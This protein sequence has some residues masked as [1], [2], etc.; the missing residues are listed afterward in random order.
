LSI[1]LRFAESTNWVTDGATIK[2][3]MLLHGNT[4]QNLL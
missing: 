3:P 1:A 2:Q 4:S